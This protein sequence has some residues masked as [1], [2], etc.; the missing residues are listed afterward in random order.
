MKGS[1]NPD[2][3]NIMDK[4]KEIIDK[5]R[6][7]QMNKNYNQQ[8][9]QGSNMPSTGGSNTQVDDQGQAGDQFDTKTKLDS[10]V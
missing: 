3:L 10:S 5:K 6:Y 1:G 9:K 2:E 7:E 8:S 4:K